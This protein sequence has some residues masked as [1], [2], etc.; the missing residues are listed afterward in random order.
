M[1]RETAASL[2]HARWHNSDGSSRPEQRNELATP[3][4]HVGGTF[5]VTLRAGD[6]DKA[7]ERSKHGRDSHE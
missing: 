4:Q 3:S 6:E 1:I 5:L 2:W 7:S